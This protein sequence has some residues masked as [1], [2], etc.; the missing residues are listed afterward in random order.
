MDKELSEFYVA[1]RTVDEHCPQ[2][3]VGAKLARDPLY[4]GEGEAERLQAPD[5][6]QS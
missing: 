1:P 3:G 2:P 5:A 4:T 6:V